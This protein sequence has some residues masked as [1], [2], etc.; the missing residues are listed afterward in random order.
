MKK[1][2]IAVALLF[3]FSAVTLALAPAAVVHADTKASLCE[4]VGLTSDNTGCNQPTNPDGS[5]SGT[6]VEGI[7]KTA[8]NLISV[9][10]GVIAVIMIIIGGLRY[11]TSGGDS[12]KTASAKD[13]ILYAIIGL[14]IVA[15]AQ[16]IVKYVLN[17]IG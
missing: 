5:P 6:S 7:I 13:T 4:G 12:A 1:L 3:N 2:L 9:V 8:I 14:V 15:L 11:I 10:V 16:V 17:K